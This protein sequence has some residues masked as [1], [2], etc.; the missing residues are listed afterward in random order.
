MYQ[1]KRMNWNT[2]LNYLLCCICQ[3]ERHHRDMPSKKEKVHF[4]TKNAYASLLT[5]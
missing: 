2:S 3:I 5:M 1:L 4:G